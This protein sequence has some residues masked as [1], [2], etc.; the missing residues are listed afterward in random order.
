MHSDHS[1]WAWNSWKLLCIRFA[2]MHIYNKLLTDML[3]V[4]G[5]K[6]PLLVGN[7]Q[8]TE[9]YPTYHPCVTSWPTNRS[10]T[11]SSLEC[12]YTVLW[13]MCT[14]K[15]LVYGLPCSHQKIND[16]TFFPVLISINFIDWFL[17]KL[18]NSTIEFEDNVILSKDLQLHKFM[19]TILFV[20]TS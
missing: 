17:A 8:V 19:S 12:M 2:K 6:V 4:C 15:C 11:N 7:M 16:D 18:H 3:P 10:H 14:Q 20:C 1:T 9:I 13:Q 5:P